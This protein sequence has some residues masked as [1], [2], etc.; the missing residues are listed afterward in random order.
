MN[1]EELNQSTHLI[2]LLKQS[3]NTVY[4]AKGKMISTQN[5]NIERNYYKGISTI[6][7]HTEGESGKVETPGEKDGN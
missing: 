3:K 7:A 5:G 6:Y 1:R 2:S 4:K